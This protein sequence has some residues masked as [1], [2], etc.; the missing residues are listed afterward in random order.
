MSERDSENADETSDAPEPFATYLARRLMTEKSFRASVP[1]ECEALIAASDFTLSY[2]DL[3]L[4]LVCIVDRES[5][6]AKRFSLSREQLVQIGRA[7]LK[8]TGKVNGAKMPV[9]I[10]LYEVGAGPL[11]S[12]DQQRLQGLQRAAFDKVGI[13]C[14]YFDTSSKTVWWSSPMQRFWQRLGFR[15]WYGAVLSEQRKT[16]TAVS[17]PALPQRSHPP[18]ATGA[19][20]LFLAAIFALEQLG[21]VGEKSSDWLGVDVGS[22]LAFGGMNRNAVLQDG[23]WY[24]LLSAALLHADFLHLLFNGLAFAL[25]GYLLEAV[26]GPAWL[27]SVFLLGALGGSLMGLLLNPP[28]LVSVGASGAVM[29]ML[30]AALAMTFRFPRGGARTHAQ[31]QLMQ[32][33]VPSLIPLATHREGGHIDYAAHFGGTLA[34]AL[35]SVV[36][37]SIWPKT[38][39]QPRFPGATRAL[40]LLSVAAFGLSAVL[41]KRH[42]AP[43]AEAAAFFA[44]DLLVNDDAIPENGETA[45]NEVETWG[46]GHPRDPRVHYYRARRLMRDNQLDAAEAELRAALAEKEILARAFASKQLETGIR[47][48]LCGLLLEQGKLDEAKR[49]AAPLCQGDPAQTPTKLRELELCP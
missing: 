42:Y 7:C 5:E 9:G 19:L 6:P 2:A 22:L 16:I 20:L 15:S 43:Y 12:E 48:L 13:Q 18:I 11:S 29:G 30:T 46:K 31:M 1:D 3:G 32:F 28:N 24:R 35:A 25:A 33:L 4:V 38:K 34:G 37:L 40:A 26:L 21:K 47:T 39:E 49:E 44:Q 27:L 10:R 8:Y 23:E 17:E 41:A 45:E 14:G 36:L